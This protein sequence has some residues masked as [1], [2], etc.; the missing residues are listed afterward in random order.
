MR[1]RVCEFEELVGNR[2][3][4]GKTRGIKE[5]SRRNM[6]NELKGMKEEEEEEE[7][8]EREMKRRQGYTEGVRQV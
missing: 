3:E 8:E 5:Q 4:R 2:E 7:E 6:K 1:K